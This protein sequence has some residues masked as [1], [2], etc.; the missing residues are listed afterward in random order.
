MLKIISTAIKQANQKRLQRRAERGVKW[1][2]RHLVPTAEVV[3]R[4]V[5]NT[6]HMPVLIVCYN[7]GR[8]VEQMVE[9]LNSLS[10]KP[11]VI[12]N[13][14]TDPKTKTLLQSLE[15]KQQAFV[16]RS[17]KNH[18]HMV[19]FKEPIYRVLPQHFAYTDPDLILNPKLPNHFLDELRELT[20]ELQ[21]FKAGM[22]LP[23]EV[24]GECAATQNHHQLSRRKPFIFNKVYS[25]IEW[26]QHFWH[27]KLDHRLEIYASQVDTTFAVYNKEMF[28][29]DFLQGVRVSGDYAAIHMPWFQSID[30]MSKADREAYL[31]GN[32]STTWRGVD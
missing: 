26:E 16:A 18:G 20:N 8:Y 24:N 11:I 22:A 2:D 9:R 29:G 25:V 14:S 1:S 17:E 3:A 32:V 4:A 5:D 7:N 27:R 12:D 21:I 28:R 15:T 13:A 30:V 31:R 19:G 23:L 10:V 6:K